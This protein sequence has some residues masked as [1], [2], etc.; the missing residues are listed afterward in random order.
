MAHYLTVDA[1]VRLITLLML[2][3]SGEAESK[4]HQEMRRTRGIASHS[5]PFAVLT[6]NSG[7]E[8]NVNRWTHLHRKRRHELQISADRPR[9]FNRCGLVV[10][11]RRFLRQIKSRTFIM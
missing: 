6:S 9:R 11:Y 3:F 10:T 8:R 7:I 4:L 1:A 2:H 5:M